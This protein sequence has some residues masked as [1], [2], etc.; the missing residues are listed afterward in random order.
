MDIVF[1]LFFAQSPL[2]GHENTN[3][4]KVLFFSPQQGERVVYGGQGR[5]KRQYKLNNNEKD[6]N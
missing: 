5:A 6:N 2:E 3:I 1:L 4:D